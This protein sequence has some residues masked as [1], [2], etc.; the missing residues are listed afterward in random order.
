MGEKHCAT[1]D[2]RASAVPHPEWVRLWSTEVSSP[3]DME[4]R[5][6]RVRS[7]ETGEWV[8]MH[9]QLFKFELPQ[10][11]WWIYSPVPVG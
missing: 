4:R 2:T 6:I 10:R 11:P 1:G 7:S 5:P 9:V 3:A 8:S